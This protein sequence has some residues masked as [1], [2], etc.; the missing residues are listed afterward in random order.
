MQAVWILLRGIMWGNIIAIGLL[1]IQKY[2]EIIKLD[3]AS[4]YLSVAPVSFSL[5]HILL[6]NL[7]AIVVITLTMIIPTYIVTKIK[8]IKVLEFV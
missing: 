3:E 7:I 1:L 2:A 6:I 8:P 5:I 4:Y